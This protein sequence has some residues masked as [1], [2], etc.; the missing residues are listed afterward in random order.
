MNA[1]FGR[2][3][4]P[5]LQDAIEFAPVQAAERPRAELVEADDAAAPLR[6]WCLE[7]EPGAKSDRISKGAAAPLVAEAVAG[8]I[9]RLLRQA[10][11]GAL[12]LGS[13]PLE[14]GD[15]AVL[16]R[17]HSQGTAVIRA[18]QRRGIIVKV[19]S[20]GGRKLEDPGR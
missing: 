7:A 2:A 5:F 3:S 16:V 12:T 20:H 19:L 8:E 10:E 11:A 18:L 17:K 9:A 15:I 14:G 4:R 6:F 13:R 1:L